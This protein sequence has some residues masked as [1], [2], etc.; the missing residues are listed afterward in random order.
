MANRLTAVNHSNSS[1]FH[2]NSLV[3]VSMT[4]VWWWFPWQQFGGGF[5]DNSLVVVSMT[6]VLVV[7]SLHVIPLP[8]VWFCL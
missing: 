4:T 3:V 2:D 6:P 1:G 7:V 5:H 8:T